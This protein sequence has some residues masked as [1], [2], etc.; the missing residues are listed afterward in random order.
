M[1][2]PTFLSRPRTSVSVACLRCIVSTKWKRTSRNMSSAQAFRQDCTGSSPDIYQYPNKLRF[3]RH[4]NGN[5][6][7]KESVP[8]T[9]QAITPIEPPSQLTYTGG[10][11]IPIT[12]LL[13][14]VTPEEETPSGTWPI[15]RLMVRNN[16]RLCNSSRMSCARSNS[17]AR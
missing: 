13:H 7:C 4:G 8:N 10:S 17:I 16:D 2:V 5:L 6:Q 12:S 9:V 11:T 15:F 3:S 14:V 1:K